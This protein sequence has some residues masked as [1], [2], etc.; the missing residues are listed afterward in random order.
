MRLG[1]SLVT[2]CGQRCTPTP[3]NLPDVSKKWK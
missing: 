3:A 2:G 1:G